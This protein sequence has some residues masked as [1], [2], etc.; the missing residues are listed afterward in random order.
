MGL[1]QKIIILLNFKPFT[2]IF[3]AIYGFG[4]KTLMTA[5]ANEPAVHS[6]YGCGSFFEGRCLYGLSDIDLIL[7]IF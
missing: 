7:I 5:L 1:L 6:V 3:R 4:L 2:H